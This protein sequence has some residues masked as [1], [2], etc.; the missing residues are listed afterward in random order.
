MTKTQTLESEFVMP[1]VKAWLNGTKKLLIGNRWIESASG[2]TFHVID[3]A[4]GGVLATVAEAGV[5][6]A[7][8]AARAARR[9]LET[10]WAQTTPAERGRLLWKLADLIDE[11]AQEFQQLESLDTGKPILE[12]LVFDVPVA[13]DHFRYFAG[14]ATKVNGETLTPSLP[15]EALAYTRREPVG[16]VA[17]IVPWNFPLAIASWKL[18]PAL[19][20]GNTVILKPSEITPLTALRLGELMLE[21]GFPPGVVNILPGFGA[22]VGAALVNH[23]GVDKISFT[24]STRVGREILISSARDF[25][26][27]TLELGGKSPNIILPDADLDAALGGSMSAIFFNQGE[28]CAAG[29]RLFVPREDLDEIVQNLAS[30]AAE[31][32]QGV[33]IDPMTQMGPLVSQTHMNR[34]MGYIEKGVQEGA[35]LVTGGSRNSSLPG[36]Y[37]QPTIFAGRDEHTIAREEI[38][39][40]VL[41]ALPYDDLDDL[42]RRANNSSY[43]LAASIWTR[44]VKQGIRIAHALKAGSVWINGYG[45][46]DATLPWGGFK[47]SGIGREM[48]KYALET[49][50]EVKTVWVNLL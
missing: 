18:A 46:L 30:R 2:K 36:Y 4:T 13:S 11:H 27:V 32:V 20:C 39:G 43:G 24:G 3:P 41:T 23:A 17:A 42:V 9:A 48:G 35:E 40:P 8:N 21:A 44:D 26:R 10:S 47:Q 12:T 28:A 14:W 34:V 45:M 31:I 50:T 33:G 25:K 5:E 49:Y 29:S 1:E 7:E 38:F 15:G 22:E 19:A 6:D 37:V 16:V